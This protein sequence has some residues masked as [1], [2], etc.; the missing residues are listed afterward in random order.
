M[1]LELTNFRCWKKKT[2]NLPDNGLI[3]LSGVS[4]VGKSSILNAIYFALFG[5]GTKIVSNG[6]K[7]CTVRLLIN[8]VY[9]NKP[10]IFDIVRTKGPNRLILTIKEL[11]TKE[12]EFEEEDEVAQK[13]IDSVF[14]T[15]FTTTS[16]ITQK[17]VQS[18]LS[19]GPTEK[20]HF[21]EQLSIKSQDISDI[22][23][24]IK[25][26]IKTHEKELQEKTGQLKVLNEELSSISVPDEI[27]FPLDGKYSEIKVKNESIRWKKTQ[28][29][30]NTKNLEKDKV[31]K[32]FSKEEYKIV[33]RDTISEQIV[34]LEEKLRQ[35]RKELETI[36]LLKEFDSSFESH[37]VLLRQH[38]ESK[39]LNR[40]L[41]EIQKRYKEEKENFNV[42]VEQETSDKQNCLDELNA[43][44]DKLNKLILTPEEVQNSK[45]SI[46]L[47]T[48]FLQLTTL[49]YA[50]STESI[51]FINPKDIEET[52]SKLKSEKETLEQRILVRKCPCCDTSLVIVNG[53]L[54]ESNND[55]IDMKN[56][57]T[58]IS[59]IT[60]NIVTKTKF[61]EENKK[62]KLQAEEKRK[63][64]EEINESLS[65]YDEDTNVE[66]IDSFRK[67]IESNKQNILKLD[68]FVKQKK[69]VVDILNNIV[70]KTSTLKKLKQ[71]LDERHQE[72]VKLESKSTI[73]TDNRTEEELQKEI[74][75]VLL[76]QQKFN[77][78]QKTITTTEKELN[79][80][81]GERDNVILSNRDFENE[82][83]NINAEIK[84]L[85][86]KNKQHKINNESIQK[87]LEYKTKFDEYLKWKSK[88]EQCSTEEINIRKQLAYTEIFFRKVQEA[89]SVAISQTI[90]NINYYMNSYLE[91]FFINDP[92]TV[93]ILSY[94]ETKKDIKPQINLEIGYKGMNIDINSLSG[95]EYDRVTLSIVLALNTMFGSDLLMLDESISSLDSDLTNEILDVLKEHMK[96]KLV[97]VVAHQIGTGVFDNVIEL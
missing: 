20:M 46:E 73:S 89:E 51:Q 80:L 77:S 12:L 29:E 10:H 57:K 59:E 58:I 91:K 2:F 35:Q 70:Q 21:L 95:G 87:Y 63:K 14:G 26:R 66:D 37:L 5:I 48:E 24:K 1:I 67:S 49:K 47:L 76:I 18:F 60:A 39:Q 85:E 68:S 13:T 45:D 33:K 11:D 97:I 55:P 9:H 82:V 25:E 62:K 56:A 17:M 22:K 27:P 54:V 43:K 90:D 72:I 71:K 30:L 15:N 31:E 42:L 36:N 16:Y 41:I 34:D 93:E 19:M 92:I 96:E 3:L 78:I 65:E 88:T 81:I 86:Q 61:L 50:L 8:V 69:E 6:E 94:K 52:I 38:L 4:G 7:K 74:S 40:T 32:E 84:V 64:L 53:N 75:D 28:K 23:K 83:S 44:I 79:T